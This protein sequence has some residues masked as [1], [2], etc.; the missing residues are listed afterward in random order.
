MNSEALTQAILAR[1][2]GSP[3][4]RLHALACDLVDG[5]LDGAQEDLAR[6]HAEHCAACAALM[7]ALAESKAVLPALAEVDPG[8][9]FTQRVLRS[10]SMRPLESGFDARAAW[11]RLMHRPRIALEAAYLGAV[12]GMMGMYAPVPWRSLEL[13]ALVQTVPIKAPVHRVMGRVIQ[14]EQRATASLQR[15]FT[16]RVE[17]PPDGLW[18]RLSA[19]VRGWL[20][21][22]EKAS[23]PANP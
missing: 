22:F 7:K 11:R 5:G 10:T 14:A 23:K 18:H 2:S 9:W 4:E 8:P 3:C 6:G 1:T 16:P 12:A 13:P 20:Q 19:R 17:A 21:R 15:V